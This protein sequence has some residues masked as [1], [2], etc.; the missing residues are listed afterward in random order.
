M[1]FIAPRVFLN[2]DLELRSSENLT[3]LA[4][5][6]ESCA[7]VLFNGVFKLAREPLVGGLNE[8]P[9]V[10]TNELVQ[11]INNLPD[12]PMKS[13]RGCNKRIFDFGFESS[14]QAPPFTIDIL[15]TR[16]SKISQLEIDLRAARYPHHAGLDADEIGKPAAH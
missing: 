1:N 2:L 7:I 11:T 13:F 15:P 16:L 6:F 12:A 14:V 9:Q 5:H 10:C 8:S 3:L 4:S